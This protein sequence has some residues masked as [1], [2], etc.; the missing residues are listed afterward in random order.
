MIA[1]LPPGEEVVAPG[2][3]ALGWHTELTAQTSV[4]LAA[5]A[6]PSSF[7]P[8]DIAVANGIIGC[9]VVVDVVVAQE[10]ATRQ[11]RVGTLPPTP[12]LRRRSDQPFPMSGSSPPTG[13]TRWQSLDS[14][15]CGNGEW[16][17]RPTTASVKVLRDHNED[18]QGFR[19]TSQFAVVIARPM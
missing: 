6:E 15:Y 12:N 1:S 18:P 7:L 3:D 5:G 19:S 8:D 16:P 4:Y 14:K 10:R 2:G 17:T 11:G 13:A 9:S